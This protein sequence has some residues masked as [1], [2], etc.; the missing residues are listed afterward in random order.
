M[1]LAGLTLVANIWA[2]LADGD[3]AVF[4]SRALACAGMVLALPSDK[5]QYRYR[6]VEADPARGVFEDSFLALLV[7][8]DNHSAV[9][10]IEHL[11]KERRLSVSPNSVYR[12]SLRK[13]RWVVVDGQG[14]LGTYDYVAQL[15]AQLFKERPRTGSVDTSSARSYCVADLVLSTDGTDAVKETARERLQRWAREKVAT[16]STGCRFGRRGEG[17]VILA[18]GI[19]GKEGVVGVFSGGVERSRSWVSMAPWGLAVDV[20]GFDGSDRV[21]EYL[22]RRRFRLQHWNTP[23]DL[24]LA[25]HE[26]CPS[27]LASTVARAASSGDSGAD[28]STERAR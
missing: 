25:V 21:V 20:H 26:R 18:F 11:D 12:L 24:A 2:S 17:V 28:H 10:V 3:E 14:G 22:G 15:A 16:F 8:S 4:G 7:R 13:G 23:D 27:K 19:G 1:S 6:V 5:V 9:V